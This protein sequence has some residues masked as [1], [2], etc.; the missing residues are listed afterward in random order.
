MLERRVILKDGSEVLLRRGVPQDLEMVWDML[1]TLSEESLR[2]LPH[3]LVREEIEQMMTDINYEELLP[4]VAIVGEADDQRRIVAV[5]TL[6]FHQGVSR[7]HRAEFDIVVHDDY[8]G[9][10]LGT[11]LTRYMVEI[12]RERGLRKVHLKT[13]TE[14][15]RAIH[16][17]EKVGFTIEG[18]LVMEHFHHLR[19]EYGDDYRMTI[20]L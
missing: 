14:N 13:S 19:K 7:R 6:S 3:P 4:V 11:A 1:S 17:Y 20:L 16:V 9:R 10:G 12:A 8:Q 2:L 18:R 15:L 5:A